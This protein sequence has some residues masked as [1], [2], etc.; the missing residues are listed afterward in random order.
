[1]DL[2]QK[3]YH[4]IQDQIIKE[5]TISWTM[6]QTRKIYQECIQKSRVYTEFKLQR[7]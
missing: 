1:M 2:E 3:R 4:L 7:T 6:D 5:T